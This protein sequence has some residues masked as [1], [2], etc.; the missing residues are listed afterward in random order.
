LDALE[1]DGYYED[2]VH[3]V[4]IV[5]W[6]DNPWWNKEQESIRKWDYDNRTR[7]EYDW[8]WE[9]KFKDTVENAI[10]RP[11]WFDACVDAHKKLGFEPSGIEVVS[12][13]PS[14]LINEGCKWAL[15]YCHKI[16]PDAFVWDVDGM[17]TGLK[18]QVKEALEGKSITII[19]FSGG[20]G[21]DSPDST[22][23]P[24][25]GE[26]PGR[27]SR[28]NRDA[29]FNRRA[30]MY[31][32]IKDR[33]WK[34]YKAV[35]EGKYYHPDELISFDGS[36]DTIRQIRSEL[37]RIPSKDNGVGK[38]Q[39]LGKDQMK[40]QGI[41]SPNLADSVMM[42]FSIHSVKRRKRN[43]RNYPEMYIA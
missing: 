10:I 4:V 7:A 28:T 8:I 16:K 29:F 35:I 9:G 1:R 5:N 23:E 19:P 3:L 22:Y 2:D 12:H 13:D 34:T 39:V 18:G 15:D 38:F 32:E 37:C 11:E 43:A 6:R 24:I 31:N 33:C 20:G 42:S 25:E 41:K 21:V 40:K 27:K 36:M 26:I 30:Q 17:G 14:D